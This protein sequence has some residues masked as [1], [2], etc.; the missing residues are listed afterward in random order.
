MQWLRAFLKQRLS[1]SQLAIVKRALGPA[2]LRVFSSNLPA[3]ASFTGTDKWGKHWYAQ[4]YQ[5]HFAPLRRRRLNVLEIGVG[6]YEDPQMGGSSLRMWKS[7]FPRSNIYGIDIEDKTA[8]A[9]PRIRIF[10]GSQADPD[11][12]R[13]VVNEM[14]SLDIVIDDG[15]HVCEHIIKSFEILFPL[16]AENGI[17]AVEDTQTSYWPKFGGTSDDF[18]DRR[19]TMGYFK[20]LADGLNYE[21]F[22]KRDYQP[23]YTDKHIVSMHFYHNLIFIHKGVN[24]EGSPKKQAIAQ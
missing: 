22:L 18:N 3:L 20:A 15:S 7:F 24:E 16:L 12:L 11:F 9:E 10:Q 5:T 14:G 19:T 21:E 13:R 23:S 4:H 6:G 1:P 8:L 2:Y 17:Y